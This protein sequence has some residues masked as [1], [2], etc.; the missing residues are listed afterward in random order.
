M[1]S[2]E[3]SE[4]AVGYYTNSQSGDFPADGVK[5]GSV[6]RRLHPLFGA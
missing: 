4:M 5:A 1:A 3:V 2:A 6:V